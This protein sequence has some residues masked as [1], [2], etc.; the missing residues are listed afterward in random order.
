MA[1]KSLHHTELRVWQK[2][3]DLLVLVYELTEAFPRREMY[4]LAAQTRRAVVSVPAN[5][6]EGNGRLHRGDYIHHL[7]FA[8][9]SIQEVDTLLRAAVRLGYLTAEMVQDA[10]ARCAELGRMLSALIAK[11]RSL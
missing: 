4:G 11:L 8:N 5:I 6:A 3:M 1:A 9:G 2:G 7:S 10:I